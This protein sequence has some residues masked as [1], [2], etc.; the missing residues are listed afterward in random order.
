VPN[1]ARSR[2][3]TIALNSASAFGGNNACV[4]FAKYGRHQ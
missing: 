1:Q 2:D 3:V 4:V